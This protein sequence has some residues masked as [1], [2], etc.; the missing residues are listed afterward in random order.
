MAHAPENDFSDSC[1]A[2][3][4]SKASLKREPSVPPNTMPDREVMDMELIKLLCPKN[5]L[6][7]LVK[8]QMMGNAICAINL[9]RVQH[10]KLWVPRLASAHES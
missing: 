9:K 3:G 6:S 4:R 8:V 2:G 1:S 10:A 5:C 7:I